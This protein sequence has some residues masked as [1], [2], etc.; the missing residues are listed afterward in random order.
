M[1]FQNGVG[2]MYWWKSTAVEVVQQPEKKARK[3]QTEHF[4]KAS[5]GGWG[6]SG[7]SEAYAELW[8]SLPQECWNFRMYVCP[9]SDNVSTLTPAP[10]HAE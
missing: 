4:S 2:Q 9:Q 8:S 7:H 1:W 5:S 10:S 3:R 6:L